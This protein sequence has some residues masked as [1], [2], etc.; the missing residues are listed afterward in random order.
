MLF[1]FNIEECSR[2]V[3]FECLPVSQFAVKDTVTVCCGACQA[4]ELF[5]YLSI[6]EKKSIYIND[7]I[8]YINGNESNITLLKISEFYDFLFYF[9]QFGVVPS[10][11]DDQWV[12]CSSELL[13]PQQEL[14][15]KTCDKGVMHGFDA[16][17][18]ACEYIKSQRNII[19]NASEGFIECTKFAIKIIESLLYLEKPNIQ[20]YPY[21]L[22]SVLR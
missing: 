3:V 17:T 8:S 15:K 14:L 1:A 21:C 7:I 4:K 18:I 16:N 19:F 10:A 5:P 2:I 11:F 6:I 20:I 12:K 9:C 22:I 13:L